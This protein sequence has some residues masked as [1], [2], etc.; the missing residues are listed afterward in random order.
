MLK[1]ILHVF[2]MGMASLAP[3][4]AASPEQPSTYSVAVIGS[5]VGAMSSALY[6]SRA[7]HHPLVIEGPNPGGA[8]AQS[9][10]VENWPG[11]ISIPGIELTDKIRSQ[12]EKNGALFTSETLVQAD[13]SKRPFKLQLKNSFDPQ[14]TR[15]VYAQSLIIAT[16]SKPYRLNIPGEEQYW[17]KGVYSCAVCDGSLYKDKVLA[18]VGGSDAA[19]TEALYLAN[20]AQTV[21]LFV[22]KDALRTI[23]KKRL[24]SLEKLPNLKIHFSSQL[25]SIQGDG[26]H[27]TAIQYRDKQGDKSMP[28]DA[29][30]LA[31][32]SAPNTEL[33]RGQLEMDSKGYIVLKKGQETSIPGVYALGDCVDPLYRQAISAAGD[34]AKAALQA[35]ESLSALPLKTQ[36]ISMEPKPKAEKKVHEIASEKEFRELFK[37]DGSLVVVDFFADWCS[38]CRFLAPAYERFAQESE[39]RIHCYKVNVQKNPALASKYRIDSIPTMMVFNAEGEILSQKIG[40][41]EILSLFQKLIAENEHPPADILR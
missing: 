9:P 36:P 38:P 39:S 29:V 10:R 34:G 6:L 20:I 40:T 17:T 1:K 3:L 31:I 14:S 30:F 8:L 28:V 16:G 5:G 7:G 35:H 32:G 26:N 12:V 23:E 4:G 15:A 13:L 2:L 37:K 18:V 21:H 33:F 41:E 11:E 24:E 25:Q 27:V 22:R 19:I